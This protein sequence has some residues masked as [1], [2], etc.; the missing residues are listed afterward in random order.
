[1]ELFS[2]Y[3]KEIDSNDSYFLT[4]FLM[5]KDNISKINKFR[6]NF[7][8]KNTSKLIKSLQNKDFLIELSYSIT[9][10]LIYIVFKKMNISV[11]D[12]LSCL[13]NSDN[14]MFK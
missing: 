7:A 5:N 12:Y 11:D 9:M 13:I 3:E 2:I 14:Q 8:H 4:I 6:N 1:M 10:F